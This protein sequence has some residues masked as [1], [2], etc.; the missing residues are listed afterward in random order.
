MTPH[1]TPT[2]TPTVPRLPFMLD[3]APESP[4][5][6]RRGQLTL[7]HGVV[8]T[9]AFMPVGT[10]G[11][12]KAMAPRELEEIGAEIILANTY[13]LLLRPGPER[14]RELGGLHR[15]MGWPRP[16]LTDSGGY[17]V[18][19]LGERVAIADEGV[20]FR[21]HLDGSLVALSPERAL[22]VQLA[23]GSDVMMLLDVCPTHPSPPAVLESAVSRTQAWAVRSQ[24]H[25]ARVTEVAGD[26]GS[27]IAPPG[28]AF[29][30]VQGGVDRELR[31]RAAAALI[32][33]DF[34]GYALGGLMVGEPKAD[35]FAT[36][37]AVN[38][39]LPTGRPRYLM[40]VGAPD[41]LVR[42][43]ALGVDL[44][45]C[46]L[47]TRNARNGTVFTRHGKIVV[48]NAEWKADER[49]LDPDCPCYT[50]RNFSRAYLRHLFHAGEILGP[51]LATL[52]SLA[53]YLSLMAEIRASIPAGGFERLGRD[54]LADYETGEAERRDRERRR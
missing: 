9:P 15:F 23:L 16:I 26:G 54:F 38:E 2:M 36:V 5:A 42:A 22:D 11:T 28:L 51:R 39:V 13:H 1:V 29:A 4:T 17:Q 43:V 14:V 32:E 30:I 46:V 34:P 18:L 48:K 35:T 44:F 19:S 50:C 45:D 8:N 6:P 7:A 53:F 52:H 47:P 20:R 21:S 25:L 27:P 24:E 31:Q 49:P 12:V 41:D 33:L 40:G 10:Q 37:A 3:G